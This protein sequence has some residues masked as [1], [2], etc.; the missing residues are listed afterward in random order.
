MEY[1]LKNKTFTHVKADAKPRDDLYLKFYYPAV[2]LFREDSWVKVLGPK[3]FVC[4]LQLL[5]M[6]DRS[7]AGYDKYENTQTVPRSL[8]GLA[9]LFGI[10]RPIF[11]GQVIKPLWNYGLIDLE[12]WQEQKKLVRRL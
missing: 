5:T 12:E 10:S 3:T 6:V 7:P 11:Y 4:W 1:L 2:D 8:E 9:K